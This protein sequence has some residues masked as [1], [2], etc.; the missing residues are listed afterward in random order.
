[1][2]EPNIIWRKYGLKDNPYFISPLTVLS[3]KVPI[4]VFTGRE[5]ETQK[6]IKL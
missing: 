5:E 1:M 2:S 4:N 3:E 6:L